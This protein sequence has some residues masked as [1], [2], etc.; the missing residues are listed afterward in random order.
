MQHEIPV[1][2]YDFEKIVGDVVVTSG[3][4]EDGYDGLNGRFNSLQNILLLKDDYSPFGSPYV[5]SIRTAVTE[6]RQKRYI[7]SSY[8]RLWMLLKHLN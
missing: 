6:E 3:T 5:D 1:G 2:I 7:S 8:A 4:D